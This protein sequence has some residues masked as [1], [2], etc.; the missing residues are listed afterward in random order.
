MSPETKAK[1]HH[2]LVSRAWCTI[3]HCK[4]IRAG[5]TTASDNKYSY[6]KS[7][8]W[9]M[10]QSHQNPQRTWVALPAVQLVTFLF[11]KACPNKE[12]AMILV[13]A[14][15][16]LSSFFSPSMANTYKSLVKLSMNIFYLFLTES[17]LLSKTP[18]ARPQWSQNNLWVL[19]PEFNG[20]SSPLY[21]KLSNSSHKTCPNHKSHM[22]RSIIAV[23]LLPWY[24]FLWKRC[25]WNPRGD[26]KSTNI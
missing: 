11:Q 21:L 17:L 5:R 1:R 9:S 4:E 20:F 14:S 8:D 19:F 16:D 23:T 22:A 2:I 12:D 15:G 18:R 7:K 24:Q 25:L 26:T 6:S 3:H 13:Q 10:K